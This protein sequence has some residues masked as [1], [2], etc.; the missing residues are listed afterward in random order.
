MAQFPP[1]PNLTKALADLTLVDS[2]GAPV[3]LSSLWAKQGCLIRHVRSFSS[4]GCRAA[5]QELLG[6]QRRFAEYQ[7]KLAVILPEELAKAKA[8]RS[9]V[10]VTFPVLTDPEKLSFQAVGAKEINWGTPENIKGM[11]KTSLSTSVRLNRS[12]RFNPATH[13]F[14]AGGR[15]LFCWLNTNLK[16]DCTLNQLFDA[17]DDL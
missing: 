2:D 15:P 6:A 14:E 1:A 3:A 12:L 10:R 16:D 8:W 7:V 9:E 5:V 17:L 13:L 4:L 11:S